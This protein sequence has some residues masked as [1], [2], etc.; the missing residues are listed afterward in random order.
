MTNPI[1]DPSTLTNEQ[2]EAIKALF[3]A[4]TEGRYNAMLDRDYQDADYYLG[5]NINLTEIF[6]T[7]MFE[8]EG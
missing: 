7:T 2:R 4:N 3:V 1:I 5:K 8:E 6:G